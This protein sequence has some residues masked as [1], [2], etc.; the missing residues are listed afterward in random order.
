[1]QNAEELLNDPALIKGIAD[2]APGLLYVIDLRSMQMVYANQKVLSLFGKSL[3]E[4]HQMGPKLFDE[5]VFSEDRGR[6]DKHI[7]E[8]LSAATGEVKELT[9]RLLDY[10]GKPTWVRTRRTIYKRDDKGNP[11][12]IISVSQDISKEIELQH[13]RERLEEEKRQLKEEK[14]LEIFKTILSTQEEERRRISESLHNGL[15]QLLYGVKLQLAALRKELAQQN[16]KAFTESQQYAAQLLEEGIRET[17]RISHQLMPSVLDDFG[18][19]AAIEDICHQVDT[20]IKFTFEFEGL[21]LLI[22]KY[23][24]LAVY[25]TIQELVLNICKHSRANLAK[26]TLKVTPNAILIEVSDN[27]VGFNSEP[28]SC[29]GMGLKSIHNKI[30]LLKGTMFINSLPGETVIQ[31]TI[32]QT[33]RMLSGKTTT[34]NKSTQTVR[35]S[36]FTYMEEKE[37]SD[38]SQPIDQVD[39]EQIIKLPELGK[40]NRP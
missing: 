31:I 15:G 9:F 23:I 20:K 2:A 4:L 35:G 12:H 25:R 1:M 32:P 5:V 39:K 24:E 13:E 8:L 28:Y 30:S 22:P 3:E 33:D 11:T 37:P 16:P 18:I 21:E 7:S 29:D 17:R 40:K 38:K 19:K 26:I 10:Q 36:G 34:D 27:G 14:Q 6:F